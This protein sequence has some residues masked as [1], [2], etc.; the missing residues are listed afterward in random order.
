MIVYRTGRFSTVGCLEWSRVLNARITWIYHK[1]E[2][3]I[4]VGCESELRIP[5][6]KC[7]TA[8]LAPSMRSSRA[9]L[10]INV[11]GNNGN[12]VE[13]QM[14]RERPTLKNEP[15]GLSLGR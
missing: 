13:D 15:G 14:A 12:N 9:V 10:A 11:S 5:S 3:Y 7:D 8:R 6:N 4:R 2:E 1:L